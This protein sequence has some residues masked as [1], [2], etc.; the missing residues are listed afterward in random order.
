MTKKEKNLFSDAKT[1]WQEFFSAELSDY[2]R[3]P[4]KGKKHSRKEKLL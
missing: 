4:Q 2:F 3:R 1:S